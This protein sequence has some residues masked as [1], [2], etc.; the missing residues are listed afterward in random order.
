MQI[1]QAVILAAG[2]SSR[3]SPFSQPHTH[4]STRTVMGCPIIIHTVEALIRSGITNI[5]IVTSPND[6][7]IV[8]IF[9]NFH[10]KDVTITLINQEKPLGMAQ[11]ILCAEKFVQERFLVINPQQMNVDLH[12]KQASEHILSSSNVVLFSKLS[13]EGEKYGVLHIEN[14]KVIGIS[15][16]PKLDQTPNQRVLGI[17][18]LTREFLTFMTTCDIEEYQFEHALHTYAKDHQIDYVE[19]KEVALSLK[20]PWDIFPIISYLFSLYP[21]KSHIHETATIHPTTIISGK[22]IIDEGVT[23]YPYSIIEGP[24]YIGKHAVIGSYS[25][26]RNESVLEEYAVVQNNVEVRHTYI[27]EDTHIHSGY[28]GDS[29]IGSHVRIGAGF[30][31]ANKRIDRKSIFAKIHDKKIDTKLHTFGTI[32]GDH[33]RIGIHCGTNPGACIQEDSIIYPGT[34][35]T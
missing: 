10:H 13:S 24:C 33:S 22:V 17:Y 11:A 2:E 5:I 28:V 34:I 6:Q 12:L 21:E 14:G 20:Y 15:E 23:T 32:I 25:K 30:I 35:V 1:H 31:S 4:K 18:V 7:R 3:F 27:G 9:E 8:E 16:K 19:S 29:L 26:V